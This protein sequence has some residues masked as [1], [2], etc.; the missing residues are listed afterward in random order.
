MSSVARL[1]PLLFLLILLP[2]IGQGEDTASSPPEA[3]APAPDS[4]NSPRATMQTFLSAM[5]DIKDGKTARMTDALETLDLSG[6]NLLVRRERGEDLAWTLLEVMDRTRE[7]ELK[8]I[9][10]R[11]DGDPWTFQQ[12]Q[13]G[14]ITLVRQSDGR[15]LFSQKT[16]ERLPALLEEL[17]DK[18]PVAGTGNEAYLPFHLRMQKQLPGYLRSAPFLIENWRW[19]GILLIVA[20]GVLLDRLVSW[21]LAGVVRRW[22]ARSIT[23][24]QVPDSMLRPLGLMAMALVWWLGINMLG[25]PE[26]ALLVL[27]VGVKFLAGISAVWTA[28][29]LVDLLTAWLKRRAARTAGTLD[30]ALVPLAQRT[31]KI[32][33]TVVG[34]IFL[35]D[36]MNIDISSLLAGL[37]LGGLAFALAA[38]DVVQNLFGSMT[39]LMDRTFSVGDWVLVDDIE[40]T[41][42]DIGFRS[43][44]IRTFYNSLVTIPNS[45]FITAAVDNMGKRRYRR[46]KTTLGLTYDT[47]PEKIEAFCEGIG[48]LVR[49]HPYMRKDYYNVYFND[50]GAASLDLLVYVF[51][52]TPDWSTELR[53]RQRFL[54]DILRLARQ[55]GVEFAFP[56]QTLYLREARN[57]Q[58]PEQFNR[59]EN[60][61]LA[62]GR[63]AGRRVAERSGNSGNP[64]PPVRFD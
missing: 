42:E 32:F 33:V 47:P 17:A 29:R 16:L 23:Y 6:V 30:D 52:E 34:V 51:W 13:A 48:E 18:Q 38:K 37:G 22:R 25:L 40:G 20:A 12:Y 3:T 62:Q 11:Q 58:A 63:E 1:L 2:G 41:V 7:V 21:A 60:E 26:Q 61:A 59:S 4:L 54:L 5:N 24:A 39:V 35:A 64:R 46:L 50:F 49:Q 10:D 28:Y 57:W 44:R 31:F 36:N 27:L 15:W 56:T 14:A 43:T 9:P 19:I 55:L 53:E 8:R 45:K